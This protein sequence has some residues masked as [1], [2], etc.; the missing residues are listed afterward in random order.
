[1]ISLVGVSASL[2]APANAG[3]RRAVAQ[4]VP[5]CAGITLS[6]SYIAAIAPAAAPGFQ[7]RLSNNTAHAIRLA[8]PVPSSSHWYARVHDRWLWRASSGA[9]GSLVNAGNEHGRVVVYPAPAQTQS[10]IQDQQYVTLQAHES[11]AWTASQQENPVLAYKPGC[12][13]CS[14]PGERQYQVVFAYAYQAAGEPGLLPCGLRS[15]PVPMPPK[16]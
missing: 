9:G 4:S 1:M 13:Q 7:F 15:S 3:A 5:L 16:S 14:Y 10:Q 8:Q 6:A 12:T 2:I 11:K